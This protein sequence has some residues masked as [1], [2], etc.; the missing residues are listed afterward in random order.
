MGRLLTS[1]HDQ[2]QISRRAIEE[3]NRKYH[4]MKHHLDAI[5]AESDPSLRQLLL[6]DLEQSIT[7][8][9]M[10]VR[11]GHPV[12]DAVLTAKQ[13]QAREKG[14]D[15]TV[16]AD[17][18]LLKSLRPLDITAIVGNALDNAIEAAERLPMQAHRDVKLTVFSQE[19]FVL[20]RIENS[21]DGTLRREGGSIVSRKSERGHGY[22]LRNI[23][24]AAEHYG[25][26]MTVTTADGWFTLSVLLPR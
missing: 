1:Q 2:Y 24:A 12:L 19:H 18:A 4:D 11:S 8:Y 9:G 26:S 16:V 13:M 10:Q 15:L 5:R 25:G 7:D 6:D 22:G 23:E 21:F 17:G 14:I 3:V 20:L